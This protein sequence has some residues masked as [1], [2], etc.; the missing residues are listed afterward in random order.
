MGSAEGVVSEAE[1]E[2]LVELV[3]DERLESH[4][5]Q[6]LLQGSP[7]TFDECDGNGFPDGAEAMQ[8]AELFDA[9]EKLLR[10]ELASLVGDEVT[11]N[12]EAL[13]VNLEKPEDG[14]RSRFL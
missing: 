12:S 9:V 4:E 2:S 13:D 10:D 7:Q 1:G 6:A 8:D 11:R 14:L 5:R 3:E